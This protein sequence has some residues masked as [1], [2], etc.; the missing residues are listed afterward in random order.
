[1]LYEDIAWAAEGDQLI[2]NKNYENEECGGIETEKLVFDHVSFIR[3][4]FGQSHF[5]KGEFHNVLFEDCDL[6]GGMF[7]DGYF[8]NCRFQKCRMTGIN[9]ESASLKDTRIE[10]CN[11]AYGNFSKT[12]WEYTEVADSNMKQSSITE[13]VFR[14]PVF[15]RVDLSETDF[16]RTKLKGI[17]LSDCT[18]HN[19]LVSDTFTELAG[20]KVDLYQ[21]AELAKLLRIQI[22]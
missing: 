6:S 16:F 1:M 3:C 10:N 18:I 19:I 13:A 22:K 8:K 11:C 2:E 5:E 7:R 21:A 9:L 15:H 12:L 20:L 4:R 17:D 14:K